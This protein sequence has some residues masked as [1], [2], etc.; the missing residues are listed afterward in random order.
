MALSKSSR[1]RKLGSSAT[2]YTR[3]DRSG[4]AR[5]PHD[6]PKGTGLATSWRFR[7]ELLYFADEL[8]LRHRPVALGHGTEVKALTTGTGERQTVGVISGKRK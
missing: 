6:G 3:A 7:P 4:R 8:G 1:R 5:A 2:S